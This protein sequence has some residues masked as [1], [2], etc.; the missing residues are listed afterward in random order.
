M[1]TK[2]GGCCKIT[3]ITKH[4]M[5]KK[6][7]IYGAHIKDG[8]LKDYESFSDLNT[9]GL[10][11]KKKGIEFLVQTAKKPKINTGEIFDDIGF[12]RQLKTSAEIQFG[13]PRPDF[14]SRFIDIDHC[15]PISND[16]YDRLV[17][18]NDEVLWQ[19]KTGSVLYYR[20]ESTT[21][22]EKFFRYCLGG[23]DFSYIRRNK[24][25][26]PYQVGDYFQLTED[27]TTG[28]KH[29]EEFPFQ[30]DTI[31]RVYA[32]GDDWVIPSPVDRMTA[33]RIPGTGGAKML[34]G[35]GKIPL[36]KIKKSN[37]K[38]WVWWMEN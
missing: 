27:V 4:T 33:I 21:E 22:A 9:D 6:V 8:Y 7:Y 17:L 30:K 37:F 29:S 14:N 11:K 20:F 5:K 19:W 25:K 34:F 31:L 12:P 36:N 28:S 23:N 16:S 3:S 10:V 32:A 38:N 24:I 2:L 1:F 26:T 15:T 13:N 18:M 35:M